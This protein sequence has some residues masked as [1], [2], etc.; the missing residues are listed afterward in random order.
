MPV[1]PSDLKA[2]ASIHSGIS[3]T[4]DVQDIGPSFVSAAIA[5]LLLLKIGPNV[6]V[7]KINQRWS[8]VAGR[9]L[10]VLQIEHTWNGDVVV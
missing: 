7:G 4:L 5:L 3:D 6:I 10:E 2:D 1:L 8:K 9:V